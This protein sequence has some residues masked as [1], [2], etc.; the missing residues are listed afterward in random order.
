MSAPTPTKIACPSCGADLDIP[1]YGKVL[2]CA[3]CG[4]KST[5]PAAPPAAS[6]GEGAGPKVTLVVVPEGRRWGGDHRMYA[7][8]VMGLGVLVMVSV[9]AWLLSY[10]AERR[11][12]AV[13]YPGEKPWDRGKMLAP[14]GLYVPSGKAALGSPSPL[15]VDADGDGIDDLVAWRRAAGSQGSALHVIAIDGKTLKE[16]WRSDEIGL[17][18]GA[19]PPR[20]FR[21]GGLVL[22]STASAL[23]ALRLTNGERRWSAVVPDRVER[24][25][26][27]GAVL[28]VTSINGRETTLRADTGAAASEEAPDDDDDEPSPLDADSG[29]RPIQGGAAALLDLTASS[30]GGLRVGRSYCPA[31]RLERVRGGAARGASGA[32]RPAAAAR[33]RYA[34]HGGQIVR[35]GH[36]SHRRVGPY[37]PPA[38]SSRPDYR[39]DSDVGVA[40]ATQVEGSAVSYLVGYDRDDGAEKWRLRLPPPE[41]V[42]RL[43]HAPLVAFQGDHA[44]V[45]FV[46]DHRTLLLRLVNLESGRELWHASVTFPRGRPLLGL[47][48]GRTRVFAH[49]GDRLVAFDAKSG[50]TTREGE[51]P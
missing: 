17:G 33:G 4:S 32:T 6:G 25:A 12:K 31:G 23:A 29:L 22:L 24:I 7:F 15:V 3:Y 26:K 21:D 1:P 37:R 5:M 10:S 35:R 27:R 44:A 19:A 2:K 16:R 28:L 43:L 41:S 45:G 34:L 39:C 18:A 47:G 8:I 46:H 42:A 51:T 48:L 40:F 49:T 13:R 20:L 9:F 38:S 50:M 30:F 36:S 14:G 11:S